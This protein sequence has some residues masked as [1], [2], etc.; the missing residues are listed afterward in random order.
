ML[1]DGRRLNFPQTPAPMQI[2]HLGVAVPDAADAEALYE[3]LLGLRPYKR[4]RVE[5]EGVE[6]VFYALGGPKV[7]LVVPTRADSTVATYLE[8]RGP[9]L[10]HV[11]FRVESVDAEMARLRAAGFPLLSD[12][13]KAGA[14]DTR[15]FFVHPKAT[16]GVLVEFVERRPPTL[17]PRYAP[18]R[19]GRLA[20]FEAGRADAPPVVV[21]HGAIGS[22]HLETG[23][24]LP[25]LAQDFRVVAVD[26]AAHGRSD[27]FEA[28]ELTVP[29]FGEGALAVTDALG[30]ES[31]HVFGFSMGGVVA[32]WLAAEHAARVRRLV[33]HGVNVRWDEAEVE[34]MTQQLDPKSIKRLTPRWAERLGETHGPD[35]W[36]RLAAR[37]DAFT[38][39]LPRQHVPDEV[40]AGI[41]APTLVSA[42][43]ADRYFALRHALHLRATIPGARL[44]VHP[45]LDH[46]IQGVEPETFSRMVRDALLAD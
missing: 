16:G 26:F 13:P 22:T 46:P 23:R 33:V 11:A 28:E 34:A 32:L 25:F 41:A 37:L 31:A 9:G 29:F 42:G 27:D 45:G 3:R 17:E 44:A 43:D 20:Y 30:I 1:A 35:R 8:K 5:R 14:D 15:I 2:E 6:T 24:L 7:E 19:G 12:E 10:H 4:E 18:F 40:L 39:A 21:L 38:R 36:P